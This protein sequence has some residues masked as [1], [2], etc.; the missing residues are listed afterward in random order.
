VATTL[1]RTKGSIMGFTGLLI[2]ARTTTPLTELDLLADS[3]PKP[4]AV[5]TTTGSSPP[6][7]DMPSTRPSGPPRWWARRPPRY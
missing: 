6:L 3:T 2:L 4:S 1:T 5:V 7:P